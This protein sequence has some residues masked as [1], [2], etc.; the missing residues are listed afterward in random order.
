MDRSLCRASA[1]P[2]PMIIT[3]CAFHVHASVIFLNRDL[4]FWASM[5][6]YFICPSTIYLLFCFLTC[7]SFMHWKNTTLKA[8]ISLASMTFNFHLLRVG[9]FHHNIFTQR[10][11]TKFLEFVLYNLSILKKHLVLF[12]ILFRQ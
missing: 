11:W 10:I 4:A 7:L 1:N 3:L 12:K 5:S 9:Y 2:A 6:T 8:K